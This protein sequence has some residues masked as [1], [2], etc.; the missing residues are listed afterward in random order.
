MIQQCYVHRQIIEPISDKFWSQVEKNAAGRPS[1][2]LGGGRGWA[3]LVDYCQLL[4]HTCVRPSRSRS[5]IQK[6]IL[7]LC[8]SQM[9]PWCTSW[10]QDVSGSRAAYASELFN[11]R[12]VVLGPGWR[13]SW[14]SVRLGA[15]AA[16][17]WVLGPGHL[18]CPGGVRIGAVHR[19][20]FCI[21]Y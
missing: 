10:G 12:P 3:L 2:A 13:S 15:V 17:R 16:R 1:R 21:E 9:R 5:E 6:V 11:R 8:V 7:A 20:G 4:R 14:G 19:E 18:R